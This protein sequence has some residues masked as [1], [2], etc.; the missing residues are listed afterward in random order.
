MAGPPSRFSAGHAHVVEERLEG[1]LR[2]QAELLQ[3]LADRESPACRV[4][5]AQAR[6]LPAA[7]GL[8]LA[9]TTTRSACQPLVVKVLLPLSR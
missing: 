3:P 5:P 2:A 1:V 9:T 7:A 6:A 8:V 4:P